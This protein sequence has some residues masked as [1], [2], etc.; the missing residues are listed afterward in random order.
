M[1][2][3]AI[4]ETGQSGFELIDA[5]FEGLALM[6]DKGEEFFV[7]G[8]DLVDETVTQ[9]VEFLVELGAR[10]VLGFKGGLAREE[11]LGDGRGSGGDCHKSIGIVE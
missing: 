6:S 3:C 4:V 9:S 8:V 5:T 11:L 10:N 1:G 7:V 2:S